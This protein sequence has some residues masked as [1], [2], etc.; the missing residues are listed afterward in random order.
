M[1]IRSE[2]RPRGRPPLTSSFKG[3]IKRGRPPLSTRPM[4]RPN[5]GLCSVV[6]PKQN[7]KEALVDTKVRGTLGPRGM[8]R[9]F[10]K[11]PG[12][13]SLETVSTKQKESLDDGSD[14]SLSPSARAE[15]NGGSPAQGASGSS[16]SSNFGPGVT[17]V[18]TGF[19][20]RP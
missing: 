19:E 15:N 17:Y 10:V 16:G 1:I 4:K 6:K 13:G 9:L 2:K 7:K 18:A 14:A 20:A 8:D 5:A 12:Q 11:R 3:Q